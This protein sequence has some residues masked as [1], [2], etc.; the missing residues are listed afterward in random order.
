MVILWPP[1]F[2]NCYPCSPRNRLGTSVILHASSIVL[3]A[4]SPCR[5]SHGTRLDL[6]PALENRVLILHSHQLLGQK[7][8]SVLLLIDSWKVGAVPPSPTNLFALAQR[9]TSFQLRLLLGCFKANH[10]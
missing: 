5:G 8:G 3:P 6:G 1:H 7:Q 10:A 2:V 4:V 9:P